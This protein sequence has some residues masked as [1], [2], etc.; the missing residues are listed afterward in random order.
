AAE[1]ITGQ[2]TNPG[3]F[4]LT[5]TGD[6]SSLSTV[7][8]TVTGTATNG[9][10][11]NTLTKN[12]TFEAGSATA[13]VDVN[14][15]DDDVYE[16]NETVIV[17]LA[18]NA[19]YTLGTAKT[20]TV[21]LVD[22]DKP[23][24]TIKASDANAA[25]TAAGQTANPGKF[26]LTRTGNKTAALTVNYTVAG[27]ATNGTDYNTLTKSVTFEAGSATAIIDVTPI[28][29]FVYEG[30]ETV[31][32]T[33]A[34]KAS[35][36]VGTANTATVN[37]ADNDSATTV[38]P[39]VTISANDA[40]ATET[41]TGQ[42]A[43]L[44]QFKLTRTGDLSSSLTVNYSVAG[45]ASNSADYNN[46]S[47]T[48]TFAA[49]SSTAIINVAP[50]DD[51]AVEG[52]ETV[53]VN[54]SSSTNYNLGTAKAATVNIFDND[55][56]NDSL[57]NA[58]SIVADYSQ[59]NNFVSN[60]NLN[61]FYRFTVSQSGIFTANLTGLTGD[62]D[63]RLI[64]DKNNNGLI[65]T[66]Q[67][68]NPTTSILDP[69]EILAWQW[70][71]GTASESIRRFLNAGTYY[72]QVMSYNNQT[73]NYNLATNFTPAASD[74]RK[75]SIQLN[76]GSSINSTAQATIRKAADFWENTISHSSFTG[77]QTLTI[78][79]S[80]DSSLSGYSGTGEITN[81]GLDANGRYMPISGAVKLSADVVN[82]LNSNSGDNTGIL[83]H[84]MGHVL[85]LISGS[86]VNTSNG[87]YN[88]N[89]YAGWAYGELKGTFTQTSVPMTT[90]VGSGSDYTHWKET[91]F[92]N[93]IMTHILMGAT[94]SLSQLSLA[95]LRD[96][97][98]NVNYGAA[99][100][101]TLPSLGGTG[102]TLN[103]VS[104]N[105]VNVAVG[106]TYSYYFN[107]SVNS[108]F[109]V[110]MYRVNFAGTGAIKVTLNG[111]TAD[112]NMRLIYDANNNGL[113]DTGEVIATA[114]NT[115]T[116]SE[117]FNFHNLAA[118][119][120]YVDVYA[121]NYIDSDGNRINISTG[122]ALNFTSLAAS[123]PEIVNN[124]N[125]VTYS[126]NL[127]KG[128]Y[129][130]PWNAYSYSLSDS[131]IDELFKFNLGG[132]TAASFNLVGLT[133]NADMRLIYDSNNNG[134]I[135]TG[136]VIATSTNLGS[137]SEKINLSGLL[138]GTY[139]LHVYRV[140]NTNTGYILRLDNLVIT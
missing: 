115:G 75:F 95:V 25:E 117:S 86:A 40:T 80:L 13:I 104:A 19:N 110:Q 10:D 14:V 15:K 113:I 42:T 99:Q 84:E 70:E 121:T 118:G 127:G 3:R 76:F 4:T 77:S 41:V 107:N 128:N 1:T 92:G 49:G 94:E 20:A 65:D 64:Q 140:A 129:I 23:T 18:N 9:T 8:Y 79:L 91:V 125:P 131:N 53:I 119:N 124:L 116:T 138:P 37:L 27:T 96:I 122:Y 68:Y 108:E 62:A 43:N 88:A 93:E 47:G 97:G 54:L 101:Y 46:L 60:L 71:R 139:Y 87:T 21:S 109:P 44:G 98:W 26:T 45:T 22:N 5:R 38:K 82:K 29:D 6:L 134:V 83:I 123:E 17:T 78:N 30:N 63:V 56:T 135:D 111:L 126:Y 7:Y 24:I 130:T 61:D 34:N 55:Y 51:T 28:D 112:A 72:L 133:D 69:G 50:I 2:T 114:I 106:S 59:I 66:A 74:D 73:A 120:Y 105:T 89:T 12:V 11:Y 39:T 137:A 90:G 85:G 16:G 52:D 57:N 35:Y 132:T 81:T 100:P 48:V 102:N 67:L 36:I 58:Q 33:L 32:L 31:I 103:S 136:E